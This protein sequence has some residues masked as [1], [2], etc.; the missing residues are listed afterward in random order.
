MICTVIPNAEAQRAAEFAEKTETLTN[1]L[2]V[3]SQAT[4]FENV[5]I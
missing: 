3:Q 2:L 4:L 5:A 1:R